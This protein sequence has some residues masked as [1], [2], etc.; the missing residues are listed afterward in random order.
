M[1][2]TYST[3]KGDTLYGHLY[4]NHYSLEPIGIDYYWGLPESFCCYNESS[5][6]FWFP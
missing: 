2:L 1:D 4:L 6:G 5:E 3:N